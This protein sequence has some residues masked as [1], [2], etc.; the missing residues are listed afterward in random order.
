MK[1]VRF[2]LGVRFDLLDEKFTVEIEKRL[3]EEIFSVL[4]VFDVQT[5]RLYGMLSPESDKGLE[6]VYMCI[7]TGGGISQTRKIYHKLENDAA[8]SM[9]LSAQHPFIQSNALERI[10]KEPEFFGKVLLRGGLEGGSGLP[11]GVTIPRRHGKRRPAGRGTK[12]MIVPGD[13]S[14]QITSVDVIKQ[15][16]TA[17]RSNFLGLKVV[18]VPLTSGGRGTAHAAVVASDGAYRKVTIKDVD[19]RKKQCIYGVLYGRTAVIEL[20]QACGVEPEQELDAEKASSYGAGELIRRA[21]DEGVSEILLAAE[22][23][24][25]LDG[26]MGMARALGVKMYD[27]DG[28]ELKGCVADMQ[29]VSRVDA[30]YI[31]P[32]IRETKITV[33]CR[34]PVALDTVCGSKDDGMQRFIELM[35]EAMGAKCP[36][37]LA[38]VGGGLGAILYSAL[39][40]EFV[41]GVEALL[42]A[43]DFDELLKNVALVV[44]GDG[45]LNEAALGEGKP[46]PSVM[47]RCAAKK[48]QV[49][50]I[51]GCVD[52]ASAHAKIAGYGVMPSICAVPGAAA[53]DDLEELLDAAANR[54]FKFMRI[55]RD[56]EKIGAPK[57]KKFRKLIYEF[58]RFR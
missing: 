34:E 51:C 44:T 5:L 6:N 19:G 52:D 12:I 49:A 30:E 58:C 47:K 40:A 56:I 10:E 28:E 4:T 9:Y 25:P 13:Y 36:D 1:V 16:T 15:L 8:L 53:S 46:I 45:V 2:G 35:S 3:W 20:A 57:E 24:I 32:R 27:A 29:R 18:P 7:F 38:G 21:L 43:V 54:M 42:D 37:D 33:M 14:E 22:D 23:C 31:H 26:G 50:V 41:P 48:T 11:G 17:A 55:G 39:K